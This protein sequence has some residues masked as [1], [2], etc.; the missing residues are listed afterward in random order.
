M[1]KLSLRMEQYTQIEQFIEQYAPLLPEAFRENALH[2]NL[3][4]LYYYT[5]RFDQAQEQLLRVALTDLNYY[6]GARVLLT[7]IYYETG[8]EEALLSLLASFIIFLKRNKQLS[9]HL[10]HTYLNFC[11]ILFQILRRPPNRLEPI[12]NRI[13]NTELLTDRAWLEETCRKAM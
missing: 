11:Q 1:V 8:A 9:S 6:L 4:E 5:G 13:K 10:K 2:Y 7:K 12:R 3:A